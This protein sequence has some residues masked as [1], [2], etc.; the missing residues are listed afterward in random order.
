MPSSRSG[1]PDRED[2][3]VAIERGELDPI[4]CLHGTERFLVD[5]CLGAIR[6]AI[7]GSATASA[8]FNADFFD[9]KETNALA[10]LAAARTLPLFATGPLKLRLVVAKG[11]DQ[12]KAEVL[13]PL[14]PYIA[15]PNPSSCL[16]LVGDKIDTRFKVFTAL[17]KAG[18]LHEF[19]ALR[20]RELAAWIVREART[21]KT[22]LDADAASALAEIA[23]PDLGRLSQ[24]LEQLS[25][26]V[27]AGQRITLDDVETLIAETRQRNVFELTKAIGDGDVVRALRLLANM[28]RNREPALRIQ[29]MLVRQMRQIWRAKELAATGAS[30]P[31]IAGA[32][33]IS[34]YFLDDVLG[35]ARRM[36]QAALARSFERLYRA[37]KTLK[38]SR[39]DPDLILSK[40]VQELAEDAAGRRTGTGDGAPAR[41]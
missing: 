13:E 26:Y 4:Y 17:R 25:L 34:P 31:E 14:I 9:L 38:S 6:T 12:V 1:G 39:V 28:L 3:L 41:A 5:R 36:S 24:A 7:L 29:V 21:R 40:L 11:V 27:G 35:P 22:A 37:D 32:V 10:V 15:D 20:D 23:G 16:V 8:S 2:P 33:G 18:Y 30:R 19:A